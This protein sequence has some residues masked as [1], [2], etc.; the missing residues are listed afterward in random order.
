MNRHKDKTEEIDKKLKKKQR[1]RQGG[2]EIERT[3]VPKLYFDQIL[4]FF[5]F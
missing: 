2:T 4:I 3:N 1:E 5:Y